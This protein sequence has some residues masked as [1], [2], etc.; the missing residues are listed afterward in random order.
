MIRAGMRAWGGMPES[1]ETGRTPLA[2][3]WRLATARSATVCVLI[4]VTLF[5][6]GCESVQYGGSGVDGGFYPPG[7]N[8]MTDWTYEAVLYV[9][10]SESGTMYRLQDKD[11]WIRVEDRQGK[12]LLNDKIELRCCMVEG[13]ANWSEFG[14]LEIALYEEG[15]ERATGETVPL[16]DPYS[17]ALAKSGPRKMVTL[18]YHYNEKM[19]RFEKVE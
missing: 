17:V 14:T 5:G 10:T 7:T 6:V 16:D 12:R 9:E 11:I 3:R 4:V 13:K 18:T 1:N 15:L 2:I 19:K 8:Y